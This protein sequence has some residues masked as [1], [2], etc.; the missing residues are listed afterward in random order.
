M[1]TAQLL[2]T[3]TLAA[4]IAAALLASVPSSEPAR[5]GWLPRFGWILLR[6]VLLPVALVAIVSWF[7]LRR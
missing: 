7:L 1:S 3:G 2:P 4:F 6:Y 5:H